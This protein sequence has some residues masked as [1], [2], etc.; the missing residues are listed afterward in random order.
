MGCLCIHVL[1]C[2]FVCVFVCVSVCACVSLTSYACF[3]VSLCR[4]I[5]V[6]LFVSMCLCVCLCRCGWCICLCDC[7]SENVFVCVCLCPCTVAGA[8]L[9][10]TL[11]ER[12]LLVHV[13]TPATHLDQWCPVEHSLV[14][15]FIHPTKHHLTAFRLHVQ[16][17][18]K[19]DPWRTVLLL[20]S[21]KDPPLSS[22]YT[23]RVKGSVIFGG[24]DKSHCQGAL[25]WVPLI[26]AR[27]W[28]YTWPG[29]PLPLR[30]SPNNA[31]ATVHGHRQTHTNTFSDTQSHRH[32]HHPLRHRQTH[33][34]ME[35]HKQ[36][37]KNIHRHI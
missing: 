22:L 34:H 9:E 12:G 6:S 28:S 29:K 35:T 10:L 4:F 11:R 31:Q 7:V 32:I 17:E 19:G 24:V 27:D 8:S 23:C 33:R 14:V 15:R 20:L 21:S 36:T 30:V 1:V 25:N 18:E 37:H 16:R 3:Y 2:L 13:Y 26:H 5:C